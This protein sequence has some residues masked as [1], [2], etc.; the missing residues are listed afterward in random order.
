MNRTRKPRLPV[1]L[2]SLLSMLVSGTALGQ[3]SFYDNWNPGLEWSEK[4]YGPGQ[5]EK[6][7][8]NRFS[9]CD[10]FNEDPV[11]FL[12][13][14]TQAPCDTDP[15]GV[16][17]GLWRAVS[18]NVPGVCAGH[19]NEVW[20]WRLVNV[21]PDYNYRIT[22]DCVGD[23]A[24]TNP[25]TKW[26]AAFGYTKD[27]SAT[28]TGSLWSLGNGLPNGFVGA[29]G[30]S[31]HV[32]QGVDAGWASFGLDFDTGDG[33]TQIKL[34]GIVQNIDTTET[35]VHLCMFVDCVDVAPLEPIEPTPTPTPTYAP[36]TNTD[37]WEIYR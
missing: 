4:D 10:H 19:P 8:V 16:R 36:S 18:C 32:S 12:P 22:F 33:T 2:V 31:S 1:I 5:A 6:G 3:L 37:G 7:G 30:V 23:E 17:G 26:F 20:A 11:P 35:D 28:Y 15:F 21:T 13:I 14:A 27:L 34:W 9:W 25:G 29:A 24:E